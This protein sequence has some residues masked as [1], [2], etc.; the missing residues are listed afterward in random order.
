MARASTLVSGYNWASGPVGLQIRPHKKAR[1]T[2]PRQQM[3]DEAHVAGRHY[4][5]SHSPEASEGEP[6]YKI[7]V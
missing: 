1:V 4:N 5:T 3:E 7:K 6:K 2:N